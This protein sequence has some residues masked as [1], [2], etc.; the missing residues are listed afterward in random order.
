MCMFVSVSASESW[1]TLP[2]CLIPTSSFDISSQAETFSRVTP[3]ATP[4]VNTLTQIEI[5]EYFAISAPE[6]QFGTF[7]P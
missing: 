5:A 4:G 3:W 2:F 1:K 6:S 7:A